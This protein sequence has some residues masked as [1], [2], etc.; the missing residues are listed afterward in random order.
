MKNEVS[1]RLCAHRCLE[2]L[3]GKSSGVVGWRTLPSMKRSYQTDLTDAE[4]EALKPHL[5]APKK[6]GRPRTHSPREIL[7]AIFY[8][9]KSGCPWRLL[10]RDLERPG[11]PSTTTTSENLVHR[12]HLGEAAY[13][14]LRERLRARIGRNTEPRARA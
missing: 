2:K 11:R 3:F 4:W 12:R 1:P 7:D 13:T 9:L 14:A 10:P 6:R 8:I 5:P